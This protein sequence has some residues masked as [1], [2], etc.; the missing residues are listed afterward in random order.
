MIHQ[1][2]RDF[3]CLKLNAA[4]E[5]ISQPT[6]WTIHDPKHDTLIVHLGGHMSELSTELNGRFGSTG[7]ATPGEV[8]SVPAEQRY[9][10]QAC[11]GRISFAVLKIPR[12]MEDSDHHQ[13]RH[14]AGSRDETLHRQVIDLVKIASSNE[15]CDQLE[16][17][18]LSESIAARIAETY[19]CQRVRHPSECGVR[20]SSQQARMIREFIWDNL[21]QPVT[22]DQ[23]AQLVGMTKHQLLVAFREVYQTT[24]AQYLITQRLR[25]ARWL[26]LYSKFDITSIALATGFSSHSHLTTRFKQHFGSVPSECRQ[27]AGNPRF[28]N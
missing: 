11:G 25:R 6:D 7:P 1:L 20:L 2:E 5:D 26:L 9:A 23:L 19:G 14:S 27:D 3:G 8:W 24:P 17:E 12:S 13:L 15:H 4:E 28:R 10:S 16:C 22:L 21:T 18:S